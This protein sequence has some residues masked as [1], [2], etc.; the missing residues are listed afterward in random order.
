MKCREV[1]S[2]LADLLLDARE[3]P[4]EVRGHL[5]SCTGCRE[6]LSELRA[7]MV[8]MDGW[9]VPEVNPYFDAKL[10]ARLRDEQQAPPAGFWERLKARILYGSSLRMQPLMAGA[11]AVLFM[12]GG[13]TYFHLAVYQQSSQ[14]SAAV[15]DLQSLDGNSQVFQ[16]LD[17]VD[18]TAAQQEPVSG[19]GAG[20]PSSD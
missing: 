7:T 5:E 6:E 12:V 2:K 19:D 20:S 14:E 13:G 18:Q 11:L 1:N 8:F 17:S 15:R 10:L 4:V 9:A 3:A 16:Q